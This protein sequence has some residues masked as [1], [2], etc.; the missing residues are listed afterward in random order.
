MP[1]FILIVVTLIP[2]LKLNFDVQLTYEAAYQW[3]NTKP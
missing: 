2:S 3:K 1:I